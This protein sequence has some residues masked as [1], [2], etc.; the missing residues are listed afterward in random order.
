[1]SRSTPF[2]ARLIGVFSIVLV[3]AMLVRGSAMVETIVGDRPIMFDL[4]MI[5]VAAGLAMVLGHNVW[6]GGMLP[7]VVTLVGWLIFVKGLFLLF[8]TPEMFSRLF[9]QIHYGEHFYIYLAPAFVIGL[10]LTVAG[11]AT[12]TPPIVCATPPADA[13]KKL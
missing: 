11:F 1:M 8:G 9:A 4:A 5:S 2:L 10:Y 6:S 12:S 7:V 13:N 3:A